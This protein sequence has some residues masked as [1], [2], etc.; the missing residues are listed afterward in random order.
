MWRWTRILVAFTIS[1]RIPSARERIAS[2]NSP[3]SSRRL[4]S[5]GIHELW[6]ES[7]HKNGNYNA[8][9]VCHPSSRVESIPYLNLNTP[10]CHRSASPSLGDARASSARYFTCSTNVVANASPVYFSFR[11]FSF[12]EGRGCAWLVSFVNSS[13]NGT[14]SCSGVSTSRNT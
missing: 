5:G 10:A 12:S 13:D 11:I 1:T 9:G 7:V 2:L 6:R 8:R 14:P 3:E 4:P